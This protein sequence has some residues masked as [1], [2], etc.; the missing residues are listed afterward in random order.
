M[1]EMMRLSPLCLLAVRKQKKLT[2]ALT[3][4][5]PYIPLKKKKKKKKKPDVKKLKANARISQTEIGF[6][7]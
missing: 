5:G 4:K 1:T 6:W 3:T 7:S 2:P